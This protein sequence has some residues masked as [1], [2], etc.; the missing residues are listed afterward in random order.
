MTDRTPQSSEEMLADL[1]KCFVKFN[2]GDRE[3]FLECLGLFTFLCCA[4]CSRDAMYCHCVFEESYRQTLPKGVREKLL[5]ENLAARKVSARETQTG[6]ANRV[7]SM[8]FQEVSSKA[9]A[10]WVR[11]AGRSGE[12]RERHELLCAG[13]GFQVNASSI[14]DL[15]FGS[16]FAEETSV[17]ETD[18]N[19]AGLFYN[20]V[21]PSVGHDQRPVGRA[22]RI[23]VD[24]AGLITFREWGGLINV[25]A[26][27]AFLGMLV[28]SARSKQSEHAPTDTLIS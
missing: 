15:V 8:A 12:W 3:H 5:F 18:E 11:R 9:K 13:G 28:Y 4:S 16:P 24:L 10:S 23:A 1:C 2:S 6:Q 17:F 21:L 7:G 22:L 20:A 25:C 14:R 26:F 27:C 19:G